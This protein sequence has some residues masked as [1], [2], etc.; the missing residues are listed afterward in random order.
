MVATERMRLAELDD[1]LRVTREEKNALRSALKLI[2]GENG[3][4][5]TLSESLTA[6]PAAT[7][8]VDGLTREAVTSGMGVE[9]KETSRP[10]S[11]DPDIPTETIYRHLR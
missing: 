5:R 9:S 6:P 3:R 7:R 11:P 4:L 10:P 2:E 8:R 1:E